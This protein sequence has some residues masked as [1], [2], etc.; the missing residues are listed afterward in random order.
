MFALNTQNTNASVQR[1]GSLA[2]I[3]RKTSSSIKV[4]F[5]FCE[6][7]A[8]TD[9]WNFEI[10]DYKFE[11]SFGEDSVTIKFDSTRLAKN[12]S[13]TDNGPIRTDNKAPAGVTAPAERNH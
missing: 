12:C 13:S 9:N 7:A 5:A 8:S 2:E 6:C 4:S 10:A 1:R 3:F 11:K